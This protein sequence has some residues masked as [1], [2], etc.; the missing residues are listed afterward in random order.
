MK[1]NKQ[2]ITLV[3]PTASGKT[4]LAIEVAEHLGCEIVSADSRQI[5]KELSIGVAKPTSEELQR[6]PHHMIDVVSVHEPY[7]A[8][9][10]AAEA[11]AIVDSLFEQHDHVVLVGGSGLY[12]QALIEGMDDLPGDLTLRA[13]LRAW[14]EHE[15]LLALQQE[16]E[17]L[18]PD[19]YQEVDRFNP[20]RLMRAIEV[21]RITNQPFS[22]LRSG[23]KTELPFDVIK[24]GLT[25][26]REFLYQRINQRVD[27]MVEQGLEEEARRLWPLNQLT[28]LQTVGYSEWFA[29]FDGQISSHEAIEK[30]KQHTRQ[31]AKRQLTWW[32]RDPS[33]HWAAIDQGGRLLS[34][35]EGILNH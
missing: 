11:R 8:G 26:Q 6:A 17:R 25:A 14:Y 30:I 4:A 29:A 21:I 2:L 1:T 22:Q 32:R 31:Y 13:E 34:F 23:K 7:S 27:Q 20:H 18:D 10:Y 19:Y 9:R 28:A 24:I 3:G 16:L 15:G 12:I 5:Y 33:I 35:V